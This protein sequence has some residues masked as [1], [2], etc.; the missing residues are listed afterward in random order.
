[1]RALSFLIVVFTCAGGNNAG[2]VRLKRI[3]S[4]DF[5]NMHL[6]VFSCLIVEFSY[7]GGI[8]EGSVHLKDIVVETATETWSALASS[9]T[10]FRAA[11]V[12]KNIKHAYKNTPSDL[13]TR[14]NEVRK[15]RLKGTVVQTPTGTCRQELSLHHQHH[16]GGC[17]DFLLNCRTCTERISADFSLEAWQDTLLGRWSSWC[18]LES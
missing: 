14:M 15:M 17:S 11:L 6:T 7:A 13:C 8:D 10:P 4:G 18:R 2:S 9:P 5:E 3:Q 16:P 1:M 12:G